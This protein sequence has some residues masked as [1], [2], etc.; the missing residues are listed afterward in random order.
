MSTFKSD[1]IASGSENLLSMLE[2][3]SYNTWKSRMLMYIEGKENGKILLDSVLNGLFQLK[4]IFIP[5]NEETKRV[6]QRKMQTMVELT[7]NDKNQLECDIR[8]KELMKGADLTKQEWETKLA[9]EFEKFTSKKGKTLQSY[10]LRFAKLMNDINMNGIEMKWLQINTKLLNN[11]QHQDPLALFA[12]TNNPPPHYS[13]ATPVIYGNGGKGKALG[14]DV[15][16]NVGDHADDL[17]KEKEEG[18]TL[19]VEEQDFMADSLESFNSNYEDEIN[20]TLLFMTDHVDAFN[21]NCDKDTTAG[22]IF[23]ANLSHAGSVAKKDI[24]QSYV[25]D[26]LYEAPT[27]DK[28]D[29]LNSFGHE[30]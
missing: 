18:G 11:L 7:N 1:F 4:Y 30:T 6:E 20:P 16:R 24:G 9:D 26:T 22:A 12:K 28:Y 23:M 8:V 27:Y 13:Y 10:Y 25:T 14:M 5:A 17:S 3:G 19:D 21:S 2:K 29:M 15:I